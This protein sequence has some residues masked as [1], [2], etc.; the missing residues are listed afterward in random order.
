MC[1]IV[2]DIIFACLGGGEGVKWA[3]SA[4]FHAGGA[5]SG[6]Q[7]NNAT[8]VPLIAAPSLYVPV[9]CA[10]IESKRMWNKSEFFYIKQSSGSVERAVV[11]KGN[12]PPFERPAS[13]KSSLCA[14]LCLP[15]KFGIPPFIYPLWNHD[16]RA[17]LVEH[18]RCCAMHQLVEHVPALEFCYYV[19]S[20]TPRHN[21][22]YL[23]IYFKPLW[24]A[25]AP[26]A[27]SVYLV[28]HLPLPM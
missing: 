16:P 19:R 22:L 20:V 12:C 6:S 17:D 28:P 5:S 25:C 1:T 3:C 11:D 8:A 27:A 26:S 24:A 15:S 18:E 4:S 2:A 13:L 21:V 23:S 7:K 9:L 14:K 10:Q